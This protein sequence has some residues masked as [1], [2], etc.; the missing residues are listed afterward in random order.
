MNYDDAI[1][2]MVGE[3]SKGLHVMFVMMN[4]ARISV[5]MQ[6]FS[7]SEVAYQ[8]AVAYASDRLQGRALTGAENPSGPADPLIVHPD[9]R[10]MLMDTKSFN[11]GARMLVYWA[12]F[13]G[14]LQ[15]NGTSKELRE[16]SGDL[17]E[18]LTPVIKGFLTDIALKATVD[19]QQIFGGHG[20]V[21]EWGMS[22]FVRD[23]RITA[24]YEGANGIQALDLVGRKLGQNNGRALIALN[25]ELE[26]F[27]EENRTNKDI[28]EF[29]SGLE[30]ARAKLTEGTVWLMEHGLTN[31]NNAAASSTDFMHMMGY[32]AL[33]YMWSKMA[34]VAQAAID[35]GEKDKFYANKLITGRYFIQRVLPMIDTHLARLKTGAAPVMA[36]D[37]ASF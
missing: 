8:N 18:L 27:L 26:A 4:A 30:G 6:A 15:V 3:E 17:L 16:R 34:V 1:G 33:T 21:E 7:Q 37:A 13:S 31:P 35:D 9:V 5:G 23:A 36:L 20:Y 24:L 2:Y 12:A 29:V 25:T 11:E 14:D 22:Q 19:C 10:R 28:K 32:L